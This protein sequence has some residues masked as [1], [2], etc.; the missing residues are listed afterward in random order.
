MLG[1]HNLENVNAAVLAAF[2][3][4][5]NP[6][7]MAKTICAFEGLEHRLEFVRTYQGRSFYNDSF[8]TTPETAIAALRSFNQNIVLICGG[9]EKKSNYQS[10]GEEIIKRKVKTVILIGVTGPRIKQEIENAA[11][12]LKSPLPSLLLLVGKPE[13]E[14]IVNL[15]FKV[16]QVGDVILL[17]PGC[18]SFDMFSNYKERGFLFKQ[19]VKNLKK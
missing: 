14:E 1:P 15:A 17:S 6:K 5:V 9:S 16:S 3:A 8:A 10:M 2:L 19:A 12:R 18:A 4:G 7:A 13:M 11:Y